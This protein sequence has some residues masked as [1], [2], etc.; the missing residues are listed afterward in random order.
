MCGYGFNEDKLSTVC[1][2]LDLGPGVAITDGSMYGDTD[3]PI[4]AHGGSIAC[5]G[6]ECVYNY[7]TVLGSCTHNNDTGIICSCEFTRI[8]TFC[9]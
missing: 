7:A 3:L 1:S 4:V 2:S 6:D 8:I 5:S 9:I